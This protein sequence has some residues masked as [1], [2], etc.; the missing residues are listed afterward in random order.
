MKMCLEIFESL[1]IRQRTTTRKKFDLNFFLVF[2]KN[3]QPQGFALLFFFSRNVSTV[4]FMKGGIRDCVT[5]S[6]SFCLILPITRPQSKQRK[7]HVNDKI[8]GP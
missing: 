5:K 6:S 4:T 7:L 3:R 8:R 1:E 2:T